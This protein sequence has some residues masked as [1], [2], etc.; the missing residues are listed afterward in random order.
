MRHGFRLD[1]TTHDVA[2][3]RAPAGYRL[4]FGERQFAV[5]LQLLPDG[6]AL[7][8]LDGQ[9]VPVVI[10]V[11]GD[12]VFVHLDGAAWQLRYEHPLQRLAAQA[13]GAAEDRVLAPMPGSI[14]ALHVQAGAAVAR[15]DTLL[16]M[17]SMKMETT[18]VAP[19]DGIVAAVH[20]AAGQ[21][22]DRDA[23]LLELKNEKD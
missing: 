16:V 3:S 22:F 21:S 10:A 5:D 17:E 11:R 2:L 9:R 13:G 14:V 1:E 15:G 8:S 20:F 23:L 7:L 12:E 4:H 6:S 19:R 18:I